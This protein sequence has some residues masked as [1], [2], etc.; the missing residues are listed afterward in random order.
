MD[1]LDGAGEQREDDDLAGCLLEH[2]LQY[3]QA[4]RCVELHHFL[5]VCVRCTATDLQELAH[6]HASIHRTDRL[7]RCLEQHLILEQV[8]VLGLLGCKRHL[9]RH[10]DHWRQVQTLRLGK[11]DG[12]LQRLEHGVLGIRLGHPLVHGQLVHHLVAP[13]R[14][15]LGHTL[16]V[17][18]LGQPV[19]I[20][21]RLRC[22]G[23]SH[24]PQVGLRAD[25]LVERLPPLC[26]R[27][28]VRVGFIHNDQIKA[29]VIDDLVC[30]QVE[31]FVV[32]DD[33]LVIVLDQLNTPRCLGVV[34][35]HRRAVDDAA[36]DV[37]HPCAVHDRQGAQDQHTPHLA[38]RHQVVGC[39]QSAERLAGAG[40][41][42]HECP[43][44]QGEEAGGLPLV[45]H[46]LVATGPSVASCDG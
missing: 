5:V 4:G 41:T 14:E 34:G 15:E 31:A 45:L 2:F 28:L 32:G 38:K 21:R 46:R 7:P 40:F 39:P 36:V 18:Q 22:R 9:T 42:E 43:A 1:R 33:D 23:S 44:V 37:S 10:R 25:D 11:A 3:R 30:N 24:H 29:P 26:G 17:D 35:D 8:V 27:H 6:S 12:W 19:R 20:H 13:R 16:W